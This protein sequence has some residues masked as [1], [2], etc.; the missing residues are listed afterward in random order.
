LLEGDLVVFGAIEDCAIGWPG[1]QQQERDR[2]KRV[3]MSWPTNESR[4]RGF[5]HHACAM[6]QLTNERRLADSAGAIE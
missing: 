1:F 4:K 3:G 5:S 6:F 2:G